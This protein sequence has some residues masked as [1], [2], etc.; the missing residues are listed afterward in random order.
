MV[1]VIFEG[2]EA[3]FVAVEVVV[4]F[5]FEVTFVVVVEFFVVVF[6]AALVEVSLS[7]G[8]LSGSGNGIIAEKILSIIIG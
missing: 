1:D 5:V 3:V 6:F 8:S 4:V 2:V 7:I